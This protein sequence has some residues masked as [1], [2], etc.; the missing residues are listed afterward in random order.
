M[1]R[2]LGFEG[3]TVFVMGGTSGINLGIAEAFAENGASLLVASRSQDKVDAAVEKL[4]AHGQQAHGFSAD[5][6]D[7]E[8]IEAGLAGQAE[9][10]KKIDVMIVGQAGN[11]PAPALGM[12][13]NAFKSVVDI[14]LLGTFN[15]VKAAHAYLG[16]DNPSITAIS[17]PQA[18]VPMP[19]QAHVCAAKAGVDML[20]KVLAMELGH[21]GVRCNGII[22]GPIQDTEGMAR[23]APTE[24]AREACRRTVPLERLGTKRD[25]ANCAMFLASP[26]A[27]YITGA[28]IP[29]DGGWSLGGVSL[30][31][32]AH[33]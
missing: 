22:P 18:V 21:Q 12:S 17:A 15:T 31:S 3:K 20:T 32:L 23:L 10:F 26:L 28:I 4:S 25:I 7:I 24:E 9:H 29:V 1:S 13:A 2:W 33:K 27:D 5:A 8:A 19:M 11:F 30:R 16:Q 6:R 14:D